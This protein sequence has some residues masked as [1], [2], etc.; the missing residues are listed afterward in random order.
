MLACHR[1]HASYV[2]AQRT[3]HSLLLC[4]AP[5]ETPVLA[6]HRNRASYVRA[7]HTQ[8]NL[9]CTDLY[10]AV[11]FVRCHVKHLNWWHTDRAGRCVWTK[12]VVLHTAF[13]DMHPA[14]TSTSPGQ[15]PSLI[16]AVVEAIGLQP[17]Y[18]SKLHTKPNSTLHRS[19]NA[20]AEARSP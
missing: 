15:C 13:H 17:Y 4:T 12:T 14:K 19:W 9:G 7:Q 16:M 3:Q 18:C 1:N 20:C 8:H 5:C 6:C 2:P 10:R 11:G